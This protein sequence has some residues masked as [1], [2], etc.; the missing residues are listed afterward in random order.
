MTDGTLL[1]RH[2]NPA[3]IQEGRPTSQTFKPSTKDEGKLST[4]DGDRI[5]ADASWKHYTGVLKLASVG[6]LAVTLG[7]VAAENLPAT[8]EPEYFPEHVAVDYSAFGIKD[9]VR[10]SK[11]LTV[12]AV[13]RGWQFGPQSSP[14]GA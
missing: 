13:A 6:V 8:P 2:V 5:T 10:K 9:I 12:M 14:S 3:W 11:K 7:E 4:Y 1:L